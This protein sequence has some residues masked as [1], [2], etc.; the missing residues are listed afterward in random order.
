MKSYRQL[1]LEIANSTDYKT[2]KLTGASWRFYV[3]EADKR[4][5]VQFQETKTFQDWLFNFLI[6]PVKLKRKD[7]KYIKIPL[8]NYLQ[9][10]SVY[11]D[12]IKA[13]EPYIKAYY[14][15]Y[16]TG[17]SQ[18]AVTAGQLAFFDNYFNHSQKSCI[19]YGCPK[20]LKDS[21]SVSTYYTSVHYV[22]F[23]YSED[24]IREAVP[25][26]KKLP[27]TVT[28]GFVPDFPPV[29]LDD[30]HRIYGHSSYK[31]PYGKDEF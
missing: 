9:F 31:D 23:L 8:G 21:A 25:C 28:Y 18:G 2:N 3:D 29:T 16:T 30:K 24:P 12:I 17:W 19:M 5:Y 13:V 6:V 20:F 10:K 1:F 26:Y 11:K 7:G 27:D 22:N 14:D 15:L 4:V